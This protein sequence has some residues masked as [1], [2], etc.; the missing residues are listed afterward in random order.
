M[1]PISALSLA[2]NII[3]LVGKAVKGGAAVVESYKSVSGLNHANETIDRE[4]ASL[5]GI[6][7]DL[8]HCQSQASDNTANQEMRQIS[9]NLIL[10]CV[11]LQSALDECRS[12]KKWGIFSA[13][14]ASAIALL[15]V[16]KI[17]K[18]QSD[19]ICSR[20]ELFR[21]IATST[22]FAFPTRRSSLTVTLEC[23]LNDRTFSTDV[24]ATLRQL[25]N[26]STTSCEIMTALNKVNARLDNALRDPTTCLG[27]IKDIVAD[28][29]ILQLLDFPSFHNRFEE[30]ATQ[31]EGTYEWIFTEP[32]I[33]LE[34][35]TDQD[36]ASRP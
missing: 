26:M 29:V 22:R 23:M 11:Q 2:F 8:Q 27:E 5:R 33:A 9:A 36:L 24:K 16:G 7:A 3:D 21:W 19:I 25:K 17:Q 30:V 6:V 4:A 15:K 20:D 18:L 1:D 14:K 10:Q 28:R 35:E 32:H 34:R 31:E 13:G 12:S